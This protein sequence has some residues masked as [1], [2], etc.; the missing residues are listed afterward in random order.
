MTTNPQSKVK[1]C[2]KCCDII[3]GGKTA[4][5]A[6]CLCHK[7]SPVSQTVL[8]ELKQEAMMEEAIVSAELAGAVSQ[9]VE[10]WEKAYRKE[11]VW[12][13]DE[14]FHTFSKRDWIKVMQMTESFI[15]TTLSTLV[16]KM[17]K[18]KKPIPLVQSR[19]MK[20]KI[21]REVVNKK[22]NPMYHFNA[23][24]SAAQEVVKKMI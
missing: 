22:V 10:G 12:A 3:D 23:G 18:E 11:F 5:C 1:C 9:S 14:E 13:N 7:E 6:Y 24:I 16:K 19:M 2:E 21:P 20:K 4:A 15:S 17:E 8:E